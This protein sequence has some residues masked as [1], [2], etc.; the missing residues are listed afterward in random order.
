MFKVQ[1]P[2]TTVLAAFLSMPLLTELVSSKD[3][4]CYRHGAPNGAVFPSQRPIPL[5]TAKTLFQ[6]LEA[7][8]RVQTNAARA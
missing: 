7:A 1:C 3:G 2:A 5:K 8:V 6:V 4:F